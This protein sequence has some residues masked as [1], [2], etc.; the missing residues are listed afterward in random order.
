MIFYRL[1][2]GKSAFCCNICHLYTSQIRFHTQIL[3]THT[4]IH[5]HTH[6]CI[7]SHR[8]K[9]NI[10]EQEFKYAEKTEFW[11]L[12]EEEEMRRTIQAS[13][14]AASHAK[15][16]KNQFVGTITVLQ[17][18]SFC[19]SHGRLQIK[20]ERALS[21]AKKTERARKI[22]EENRIRRGIIAAIKNQ[23]QIEPPE[24]QQHLDM[25][26][27]SSVSSSRG[28]SALGENRRANMSAGEQHKQ[29]RD[30]GEGEDTT[31]GF[32]VTQHSGV[33]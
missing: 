17:L 22:K 27:N 9:L 18:V 26:Q 24:V 8:A 16:H 12:K 6:T 29:P 10:I 2:L 5:S 15:A 3:N 14:T 23:K 1:R 33:E 21:E 32:F 7:H 11:R 31:G 4:H 19:L 20:R 13:C 25:S 28:Y 30:F